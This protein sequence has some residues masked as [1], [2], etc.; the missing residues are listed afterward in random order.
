[1]QYSD[2]YAE[3]FTTPEH[4]E[5]IG[6]HQFWG[7]NG[8]LLFVSCNAGVNFAADVHKQYVSM[9]NEHNSFSSQPPIM[10]TADEPITAIFEDSETCPRLP[11]HVAGSDAFVFQCSHE[12]ENDFSVNENIQQ[13]LQVVRTLNAHRA[14]NITVVMPYT[15][16]TRQ[17]KPTFM[18]REATLSKLFADQLK[19]AGANSLLTYHP[20]S[21]SLHGFF[22]PEMN[23][24]ALSGLELFLE[25]FRDKMG[26]SEVIAVSTDAGGAKF[27]VHF[28]EA[29]KINYAITNKFRR[30][31]DN[32]NLLGIIGDI[33]NKK[34]AII[35]D[36]ETVTGKSILNATRQLY[37]NYGVENI[38]I[39]VSHMKM[40]DR[41]IPELIDAHANFGL[42]Q[43]HFTDTVG[44]SPKI[45]N[46]DFVKCHPVARRFAATI[47]Q[48]HYNRSISKL[49]RDKK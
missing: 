18:K 11:A 46:L 2:R 33:D 19:I 39:A 48:M 30:G 45:A 12:K 24:Y 7:P 13:L 9:L 37:K 27:T 43:L 8:W 22:E 10:G 31:K 20:H 23:F 17:D 14:K 6:R 44:F 42:R 21:Y 34:S 47:N 1:M 32:A 25:I 4:F 26:D 41:F 5:I 16:Y 28:A 3:L 38:Y 15:P 36:D 49:F 29:M 40:P 35:T